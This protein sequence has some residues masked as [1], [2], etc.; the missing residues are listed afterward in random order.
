MG[1][2]R[3][4]LTEGESVVL[5]L[6]PHWRRVALPVIG[7][8]V[9]VGVASYLAALVGGGHYQLTER[10][11]IGV[12]AL[13]VLAL[14]CLRPWLR[15]QS[16]RFVVTDRRIVLRQGVLG[17]RGRDIPLSRISD[18]S[19]TRSVAERLFR[20]GTL[21]LESSGEQGRIAVPDVP[22]VQQVARTIFELADR[23]SPS[24]AQLRGATG[25]SDT[26]W[27]QTRIS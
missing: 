10:A 6:H 1:F 4:L 21:V 3:R 14:A 17:R 12:V 5:D 15:W 11:A 18:V 2:P 25:D 8:P 26:G 22:R 24:S 23:G 19:V 7:V 27:G 9:I 13:I 16:T 20:T